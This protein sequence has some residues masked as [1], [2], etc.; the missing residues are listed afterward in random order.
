[1]RHG[2]MRDFIHGMSANKGWVYICNTYDVQKT[3]NWHAD[4]TVPVQPWMTL[5]HTSLRQ[6][7][8]TLAQPCQRRCIAMAKDWWCGQSSCCYASSSTAV[9]K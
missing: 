2:I 6:K 9:G 8:W 5:T 3:C 1:M 7:S 4:T